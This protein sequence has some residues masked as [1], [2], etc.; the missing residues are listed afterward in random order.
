MKKHL[1]GQEL[2]DAWKKMEQEN[3]EKREKERLERLKNVPRK[4]RNCSNSWYCEIPPR[5][6]FAESIEYCGCRKKTAL[7]N[8]DGVCK[9]FDPE[10]K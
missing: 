4:C 2:L 8:P 9:D 5:G 7:V 1:S 10:S 3:R 6:N